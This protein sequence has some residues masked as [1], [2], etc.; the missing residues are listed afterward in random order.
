MGRSAGMVDRREN[1]C[2][3]RRG[4]CG[5]LQEPVYILMG[6]FALLFPKCLL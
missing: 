4:F 2:S 1:G 5:L 3:L 6:A